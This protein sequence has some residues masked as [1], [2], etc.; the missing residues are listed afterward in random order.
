MP[1]SASGSGEDGHRLPEHL[2]R[3]PGSG[4][5]DRDLAARDPAAGDRRRGGKHTLIRDRWPLSGSSLLSV[6][7]PS[8]R[9]RY[10]EIA[11]TA[12]GGPDGRPNR[13]LRDPTITSAP[14][15]G[16]SRCDRSG[17]GPILLTGSGVPP[18]QRLES[19]VLFHLRG[20]DRCQRLPGDRRRT[21]DPFAT[22]VDPGCQHETRVRTS[23]SAHT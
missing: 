15:H 16:V 1:T 21:T 2:D 18:D 20:P 9:F 13:D 4:A 12:G 3:G 5:R 19:E 22:L 10:D 11:H 6:R 17:H 8:D 23:W 14:D 7:A